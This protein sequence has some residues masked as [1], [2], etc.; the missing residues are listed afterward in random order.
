MFAVL[1]ALTLNAA[2]TLSAIPGPPTAASCGTCTLTGRLLA[3][4]DAPLPPPP[5]PDL[6]AQ[7]PSPGPDVPL[8]TP[9]RIKKLELEIDR[10]SSEIRGIS[11]NWPTLYIVL[12]YGGY[13]LAVPGILA[14]GALLA[15]GLLASTVSGVGEAATVL[16]LLGGA[17]MVV[18]LAGVAAIIYGFI[19]GNAVAEQARARRKELSEQRD[20]LKREL[21][22]LRDRQPSAPARS[23]HM[24]TVFAF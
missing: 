16:L 1:T 11:T 4:A 10:L 24:V 19:Q 18:G 17:G 3:Q 5:L 9:E 13:V 6:D 23:G 7:D 14:G 8:A 22:E 21:Q 2:V 12:G 20:A 15:S